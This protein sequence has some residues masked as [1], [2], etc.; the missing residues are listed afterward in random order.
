MANSLFLGNG[1]NSIVAGT[2]ITISPTNGLGDVT[3]NATSSGTVSSV[4]VVT[5]NGV[6][7][8]VA[9]ATT[10]P[11]ITLTLGGITPSSVAASGG[12]S[13]SVGSM[14]SLRSGAL[15]LTSQA[16]GDLIGASS[17][18]QLSR[19]AAA[20]AG[21][22]LISGGAA[23]LPKYLAA[24]TAGQFLMSNGAGVDPSYASAAG[25]KDIVNGRL[26]LQS[27]VPVS[28]TDQATKGTL[29]FALYNGNQ[30]GLYDGSSAWTVLTFAE[31]SITLNGL[32]A[33]KPYDVFV[34]N[35]SGTAA[36]ELLVWTNTTTRATALVL[37]DGV[38]V[39]T[40]A[41]T[42]RYLGTILLN[43]TGNDCDDTLAN[44][45]VWNLYNQV[46]RPVAFVGSGTATWVTPAGTY[47]ATG[48]NAA[49][50]INIL[51]GLAGLSTLHLMATNLAS[52]DDASGYMGSGI[53][54]DSSTTNSAQLTTTGV[55]GISI[56]ASNPSFA[57]YD[58]YPAL[59]K[60]Q[61]RWLE[62]GVST[63]GVGTAT[64]QMGTNNGRN[65]GMAGIMQR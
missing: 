10:T 22:V 36:L 26:T 12:V 53:G 62:Y 48:N 52:L 16:T 63:T 13:D 61:Y 64:I 44:P 7:G 33:S 43:A 51:V 56:A 8:S 55:V 17:A 14:A 23:T 42:R 2:N 50:S 60:R 32:T 4:S 35:N 15:G 41:T 49:N 58:G 65:M 47:R 18:T 11:A 29:Y 24:G 6:S 5:A 39:K 27:G 9:T 57:V 34:Y 19:I 45:G 38:Y 31:L 46:E 21:Q 54:I 28:T 30:V 1:V 37:Q 59:G 40:G 25:N 20:A 3:I